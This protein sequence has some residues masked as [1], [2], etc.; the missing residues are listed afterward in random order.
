MKY[1]ADDSVPFAVLTE[2][3]I[4]ITYRSHLIEEGKINFTGD[5]SELFYRGEFDNINMTLQ[6]HL[7][8]VPQE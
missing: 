6:I 4:E 8:S 1:L 3:H 7:T 2:K 5:K